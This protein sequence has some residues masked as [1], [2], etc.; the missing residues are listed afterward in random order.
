MIINVIRFLSNVNY[1]LTSVRERRISS[2]E[3]IITAKI[4]MISY[5]VETIYAER[6]APRRK[7]RV[8]AGT[9]ETEFRGQ[10]RSKTEF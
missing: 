9:G 3:V 10:V 7:G 4:I 6:G 8:S 5:A 1:Y 2:A